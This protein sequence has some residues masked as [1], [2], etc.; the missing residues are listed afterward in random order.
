MTYPEG[1][2]V[3]AKWSYL[4][5]KKVMF[6][7]DDAPM[8]ALHELDFDLRPHPDLAPRTF[9]ALRPNKMCTGK[10]FELNY[11]EAKNKSKISRPL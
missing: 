6:H 8:T 4:K 9:P 5:N 10:K 1:T 3:A 2:I 11:F 7:Q